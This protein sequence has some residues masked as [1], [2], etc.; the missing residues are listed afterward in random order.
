MA[1]EL[2]HRISNG[3]H[4]HLHLSQGGALLDQGCSLQELRGVVT[5][6]PVGC[7]YVTW[8][9]EVRWALIGASASAN[10]MAPWKAS[11]YVRDS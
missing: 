2:V 9:R 6:G 8:R 10:Y 1:A 5:Y 3:P 4:G 11:T 7:I